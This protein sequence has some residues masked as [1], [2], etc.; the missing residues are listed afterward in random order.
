MRGYLSEE[1]DRLEVRGRS[2]EERSDIFD[3]VGLEV[4]QAVGPGMGCLSGETQRL[5]PHIRSHLRSHPHCADS[6]NAPTHRP[7]T[8]RL[9]IWTRATRQQPPPAWCHVP[10]PNGPRDCEGRESHSLMRARSCPR[11]SPSALIRGAGSGTGGKLGKPGAWS[12]RR[13]TALKSGRGE[14]IQEHGHHHSVAALHE[15]AWPVPV[16]CTDEAARDQNARGEHDRTS[17]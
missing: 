11:V 8:A 4:L 17:S 14:G 5:C 15:E 6:H 13:C 10:P 7:R 1:T 2:L 9:A 3:V 16:P 12:H